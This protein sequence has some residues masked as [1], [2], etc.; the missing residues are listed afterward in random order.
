MTDQQPQAQLVIAGGATLFDYQDYRR[1]FMTLVE[2]YGLA[3]AVILPG[4]GAR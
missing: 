2:Q 4:G 3:D 1:E